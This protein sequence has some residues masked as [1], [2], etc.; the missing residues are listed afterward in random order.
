MARF[1]TLVLVTL[2]LSSGCAIAAQTWYVR[3][4]GGNTTG[5]AT[6]CDLGDIWATM[7]RASDGDTIKL[8]SGNCTWTGGGLG[9]YVTPGSQKALIFTGSGTN[10]LP[11]PTINGVNI[12]GTCGAGT[13]NP[14]VITLDY[15]S[16]PGTYSA[17]DLKPTPNGRV[18]LTNIKFIIPETAPTPQLGQYIFMGPEAG[19]PIVI[20]HIT[21]ESDH[22]GS[23]YWVRNGRKT[24]LIYRNR[25][26]NTG[27]WVNGKVN[28]LTA[29]C[30]L[31]ASGTQWATIST[32]GKHDTDGAKNFYVESNVFE[33]TSASV[34]N[35]DECKMVY[36]WNW[37]ND[38]A[39][40][41]HG[42]DT[43]GYGNRHWELYNNEF[44]CTVFHDWFGHFSSRGG[45]GIIADN[46]AP[47]IC[48][49]FGGHA[50]RAQVMVLRRRLY[51]SPPDCYPGPYPWS[52]QYGWGWA[53]SGR[54]TNQRKEPAYI[55]G[56]KLTVG[57][58]PGE[59]DTLDHWDSESGCT[60]DNS[61]QTTAGYVQ[62]NR[63]YYVTK[64][65][66]DGTVGIG[67]RDRALPRASRPAT[68]T[69]GVGWLPSENPNAMDKCTDG[70]N[71]NPSLR[72]TNNWYEKANYPHP[73]AQA[74]G[75]DIP[76]QPTNANTIGG[77]FIVRGRAMVR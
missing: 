23:M 1:F 54:E 67:N 24:G 31:N 16:N 34:D 5:P 29:G 32:L 75:N 33:N 37:S 76:G 6:S 71:P 10:A 51:G 18:V 15:R 73:V 61:S 49:G 72:W 35:D 7:A 56:N 22:V 38:S 12:G 70:S 50:W 26:K 36:R 8:A 45:T 62:E 63:E 58:T 48:A 44:R 43:S 66:F 13:V 39:F 42:R 41:D 57:G 4:R 64:L 20:H 30:K 47:N 59:N 52:H 53:G 14:T 65:S 69:T 40:A 77:G 19:Q 2:L 55:F 17:I 21:V 74:L 9:N 25:V 27:K 11:C 3:P 28:A 46:T 60:F 68:C